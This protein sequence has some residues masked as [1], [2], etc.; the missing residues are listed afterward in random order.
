[1]WHPPRG[2]GRV[3]NA[4]PSLRA[5]CTRS[6]SDEDEEDGDDDDDNDDDEEGEGPEA[7]DAGDDAR[8]TMT[9]STWTISTTST[10]PRGGH[11]ATWENLPT[12]SLRFRLP[13]LGF[14][15]RLSNRQPRLNHAANESF[16]LSAH[17]RHF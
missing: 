15:I 11:V 7:A 1:M 2:D 6:E 12:R 8:A 13:N 16:L 3:R 17:A 14:I 10:R 9:R 4:P 5:S